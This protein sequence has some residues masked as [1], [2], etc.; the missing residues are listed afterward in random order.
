M[1]EAASFVTKNSARIDAPAAVVFEL[2]RDVERWTQLFTGVVFARRTPTGADTDETTVWLLREGERVD[3]VQSRRTLEP[4]AGRITVV[5]EPGTAPFRSARSEWQV[6]EDGGTGCTLSY[7]AEHSVDGPV[8]PHA[9]R[10][11]AWIS[12]FLAQLGAVA[13]QHT[14]LDDLIISFEDELFIA[15]EVADVYGLL[16]RCAQWPERFPHVKRIVLDE[17]VPNVQFFDMDTVTPEGRAHT[18]RSVRLCFPESLIVYK[19]IVLPPLL[20]AHTG[21]WRFTPTR[22]GMLAAAKHTATIKPGGL[23]LLGEGTTVL[24]ARKYLR[25]VLSAN[26]MANLRYAK[27][28]AEQRAGY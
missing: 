12:G 1:P 18:T 15:G 5:D 13:A 21:H 19:Q 24:E 4:A 23:H 8:E 6:S 3:A 10:L 25:R 22:E 2:L 28:F 9:T 7:L 26:S 16:Y 11:D 17:D 27:E 14:E 20:T